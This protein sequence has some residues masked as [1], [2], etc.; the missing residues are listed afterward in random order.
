[1]FF[2]NLDFVLKDVSVGSLMLTSLFLHGV[3]VAQRALNSLALVR[4]Q[5]GVPNKNILYVVRLHMH[6]GRWVNSQQCVSVW[7]N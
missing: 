1:M 3:M 7:F 5:M 4:F 6:S 2:K